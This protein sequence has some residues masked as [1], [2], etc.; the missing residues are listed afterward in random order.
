F[1][2][3]MSTLNADELVQRLQEALNGKGRKTVRAGGPK[4]NFLTNT[5][6]DSDGTTTV[7]G[8]APFTGTEK[9]HGNTLGHM[10]MGSGVTK[11][12]FCAMT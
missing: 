12:G 1:A 5:P 2:L 6:F 8:E 4:R 11:E 10:S 7:L 3:V 9:C